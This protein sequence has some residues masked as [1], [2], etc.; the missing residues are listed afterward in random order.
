MLTPPRKGAKPAQIKEKQRL[1]TY[2]ASAGRGQG[3]GWQNVGTPWTLSP[4]KPSGHCSQCCP[5]VFLWQSFSRN[6]ERVIKVKWKCCLN[7][8]EIIQLKTWPRRIGADARPQPFKVLTEAAKPASTAA[9]KN[10][11][12]YHTDQLANVGKV[13]YRTKQIHMPARCWSRSSTACCQRCQSYSGVAGSPV[14]HCV[15]Q[16]KRFL[17][18]KPNQKISAGKYYQ[19][20]SVQVQNSAQ[21]LLGL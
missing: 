16:H 20:I 9:N 15:C 1:F 14:L 13:R 21:L 8:N 10:T 18:L 17:S 7:Q 3:Q 6:I 11:I 2:L 19:Q 12:N 4:I 5:V